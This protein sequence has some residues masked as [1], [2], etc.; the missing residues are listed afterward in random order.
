MFRD[1]THQMKPVEF[2]YDDKREFVLEF[3]WDRECVT[4]DWSI[5]AWAETG[6]V[7]VTHSK[8]LVSDQ[9][10]VLDT[11]RI[12]DYKNA[13]ALSVISSAKSSMPNQNT[14]N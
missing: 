2:S 6:T 1:G 9:M 5:T 11:V 10:P 13:T 4:P 3:D 12:Y 7:T 14:E 8:G